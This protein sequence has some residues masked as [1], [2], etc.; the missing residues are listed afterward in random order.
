MNRGKPFFLNKENS[1]GSVNQY[2]D[3]QKDTH[4]FVDLIGYFDYF[5][6]A[7]YLKQYQQKIKDPQ[8]KN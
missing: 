5:E 2:K 7:Q 3:T 6:P 4:D 1:N 8:G